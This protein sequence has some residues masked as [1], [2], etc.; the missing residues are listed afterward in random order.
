MCIL[1]PGPWYHGSPA[2]RYGLYA[3]NWV[4]RRKLTP[5]GPWLDRTWSQRFML[6]CDEPLSNFA[7]NVNLRPFNWVASVN[8]SPTP[9]LD[10]FIRV[11]QGLQA[12]GV[13]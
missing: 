6:N 1:D 5:G 11:V 8:G 2:Q 13:Y 10:T 12:G 4:G 3:L 9:D 7:L